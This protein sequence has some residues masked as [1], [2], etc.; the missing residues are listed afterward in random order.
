MLVPAPKPLFAWDCLEDNPDLVTIRRLFEALPD[1][2]LLEGLRSWRGRG[3]N[4]YPVQ[5]LW[6][7]VVLTIVLRHREQK[8]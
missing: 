8:G 1:Q 2:T 6:R 7:V 4:D 5:V 3:R